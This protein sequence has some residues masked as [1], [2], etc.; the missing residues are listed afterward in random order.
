L[1]LQAY[2]SGELTK[3]AQ[4]GND[5]FK[6]WAKALGKAQGRKGK[7]LFMPLRIALTG[8]MQGPEVGDVLHLLSL[9]DA[10]VADRTAFVPLPARMDQLREWLASRT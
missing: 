9:E 2:D 5:A 1:A 4:E 10:D 6:G 7:R 3:A 8:S